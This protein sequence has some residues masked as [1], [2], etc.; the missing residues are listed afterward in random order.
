MHNGN[1]LLDPQTG[2]IRA[3]LDYADATAGD[4]RWELAWFDYYFRA[5][6]PRRPRF[7]L[8]RFH[9]GYGSRPD[10]DD[11]AGRFYRVAILVFEKLHF[12]DPTSELGAW[13]VATLKKLLRELSTS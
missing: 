7:D 9:E 12:Y 8:R 3:V 2:R 13:A 5:L 6:P 4:P 10:P 11:V 1:V